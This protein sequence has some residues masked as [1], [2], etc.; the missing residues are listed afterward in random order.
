MFWVA[1]SFYL[2][3]PLFYYYTRKESRYPK[4]ARLRKV[5]CDIGFVLGFYRYK[6]EFEVPVDFNKT[7]I[8]VLNH[9]S[10]LDTPVICRCPRLRPQPRLLTCWRRMRCCMQGCTSTGTLFGSILEIF[11]YLRLF[12]SPCHVLFARRARSTKEI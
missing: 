6:T 9:S 8:I 7:M 2:M 12:L 11:P 10:Y 3:Y 4:V 5:W 1:L